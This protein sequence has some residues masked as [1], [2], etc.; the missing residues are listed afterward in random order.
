MSEKEKT[1]LIVVLAVLALCGCL[2]VSCCAGTMFV[3]SHA[4]Q[5]TFIELLGGSLTSDQNDSVPNFDAIPDDE[6]SFSNDRNDVDENGLSRAE[7]LVI[8]ETEK[9]RGLSA[10]E[11]F[12]PVYQTEAELREYMIDE[13]NEVTDE[14]FDKELGLYKILGFAPENFDLRQFYVDMYSEQIAGFFDPEDNLMYL[15]EDDSPYNNAVTLSHEYTHFLQYNHPEFKDILNYDDDFCEKNGETCIVLDALIEGDA[16]L[17]ESLV[18]VDSLIGSYRS[19]SGTQSNADTSVFDS[20]P[21]FFQESLLF[22]YVSG[23]DFVSYHYLKGGFDKVNELY[24]NLPQSVEQI[25]HP[26]KYLKDAPVT[27][28][29][30]PFRSIISNDFEII[31]E[32]VLNESDI[33]M[34]LS[35]GYDQNWQLTDRQAS[36]GADGW[37]GGSFIFARNNGSPLFFSKVVWDSVKDA[38][39]AEQAFGLYSEKRFGPSTDVNV[40]KSEDGSSVH[41]IRQDDVLYWMILPDNFDTNSFIDLIRHGSVL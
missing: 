15:I 2:V 34:L 39:E 7:Q 27:V 13:L 14:D 3:F 4:D 29:M 23:Y 16:T 25:M 9:I 11:K 1:I 21:K 33:K 41:L 8:A 22:S 20:A 24:L 26:E 12:A 31:N 30:E 5:N 35:C 28:M 17:T 37:G 18:D 32:D 10:D 36:A 6:I 19:N 38:E 40:W